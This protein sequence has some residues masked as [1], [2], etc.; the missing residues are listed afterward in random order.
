VARV[1]SSLAVLGITDFLLCFFMYGVLLAMLAE[2]RE[3]QTVLQN[4]FI[5][6]RVIVGLLAVRAFHLDKIIL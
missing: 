5:F 4:L 2:F 1:T 6:L 3:F